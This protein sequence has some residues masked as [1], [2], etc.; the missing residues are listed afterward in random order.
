LPEEN[1][2]AVFA[3]RAASG[4][5]DPVAEKILAVLKL[6]AVCGFVFLLV[7]GSTGEA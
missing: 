3:Q 4:V 5:R 7:S 2:D 1:R 6:R